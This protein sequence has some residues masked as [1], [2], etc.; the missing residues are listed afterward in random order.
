MRG[1]EYA[2]IMGALVVMVSMY[3]S[4]SSIYKLLAFYASFSII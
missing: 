2:W 3:V 4:M 1:R